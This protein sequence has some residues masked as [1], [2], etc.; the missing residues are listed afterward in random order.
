M[1]AQVEKPKENRKKAVANSVAQKKDNGNQ[2][3]GFVDNRPEATGGKILNANSGFY[4]PQKEHRN[5]V[6]TVNVDRPLQFMQCQHAKITGGNGII[7]KARGKTNY[8]AMMGNNNQGPHTI[9][10]STIAAIEEMSGLAGVE[11]YNTYK[12]LGII[13]TLN[14]LQTMNNVD[15]PPSTDL[16]MTWL[17][18]RYDRYELAYNQALVNCEYWRLEYVNATDPD[19]KLD[20]EGE[21]DLAL[22][23]IRDMHPASTYAGDILGGATQAQLDGKGEQTINKIK[24]N[25]AVLTVD[26]YAGLHAVIMADADVGDLV[27]DSE[28]SNLAWHYVDLAIKSMGAWSARP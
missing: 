27:D 28:I 25:I 21:L 23:D 7:Q 14:T 15:R 8:G 9:A 12:D 11:K 2:G 10:H 6:L 17:N 22:N 16:T 20:A 18:D 1:Y 19:E 3:V 13:L 5:A 26:D 4:I 24:Q